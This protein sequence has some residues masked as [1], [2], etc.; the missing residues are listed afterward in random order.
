MWTNRI[1]LTFSNLRTRSWMYFARCV[2]VTAWL[3]GQ[4]RTSSQRICCQVATC[5]FKPT[6][7]IMSPGEWERKAWRWKVSN[8][9]LRR[10][11]LILVFPQNSASAWDQTF[12]LERARGPR[13][14]RSGT[15]RWWLTKWSLSWQLSPI[16]CV[17]A[18]LWRR[19]TVLTLAGGKVGEATGSGMTST[20]TV[21]MDFTS[22]LVRKTLQQYL[23]LISP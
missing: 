17:W 22:G 10:A 6:L 19:A 11:A 14:T 23:H 9:L 7:S 2:C 12:S 13:S 20:R 3:S 18:G 15:L 8:P 4:T 5:C 16:T 21:L 1:F